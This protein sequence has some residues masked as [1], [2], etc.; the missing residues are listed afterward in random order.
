VFTVGLA[1]R[2][3]RPSYWSLPSNAKP[4]ASSTAHRCHIGAIS[5]SAILQLAEDAMQLRTGTLN[6]LASDVAEKTQHLLVMACS[7]PNNLKWKNQTLN[8]VN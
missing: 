8:C 4:Y 6:W 2:Y 5:F 1:A 3:N 7:K